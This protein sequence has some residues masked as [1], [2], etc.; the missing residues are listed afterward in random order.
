MSGF[1]TSDR[2]ENQGA[3]RRAAYI[4]VCEHAK[5]ARHTEIHLPLAGSVFDGV[6]KPLLAVSPAGP[7]E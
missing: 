5:E 7:V 3:D 4:A 2:A 6:L 1:K